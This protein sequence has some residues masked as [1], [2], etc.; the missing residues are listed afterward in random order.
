MPDVKVKDMS[1]DKGELMVRT[2]ATWEEVLELAKEKKQIYYMNAK[3]NVECEW[4]AGAVTAHAYLNTVF[5]KKE[6][7][8]SEG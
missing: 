6:P 2:K 4:P 3:E 1:R 8:R 5:Y 7:Y